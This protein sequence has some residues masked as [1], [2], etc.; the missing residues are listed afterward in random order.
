V[1]EFSLVERN[2]SLMLVPES[3][4]IR[5]IS[6]SSGMLISAALMLVA[7]F[8]FGSW[9]VYSSYKVEQLA[10][11]LEQSQHALDHAQ[12]RYDVKMAEWQDETVSD[13]KKLAVYSR[14]LGQMQARLSRLD[15]LGSKLV[16][17][18]ALDK[19]EFDFGVQPAFGGP[20]QTRPDF[21]GLEAG[22][23][24]GLKYLDGRMEQL[25]TQLAAIDYMLENNRS[26]AHAKPHAWPTEGGWL[27][28]NYGRRMDPFT[29]NPAN[30][31]GVDIANRFGAP[32]LASSR[33]IVTFAGKMKDFGYMV[34][35]DHGYGYKTRYGHMSSVSVKVGDVVNDSQILGR[36]GSSGRSTGPH[37]HYEVHLHGMHINPA[38]YLPRS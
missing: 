4:R 13:Q 11:T 26:V 8:S 18:A 22:L 34:D 2:Y 7:L 1:E 16:N 19:S 6:L 9:G 20:R 31:Y 35:V 30:H 14:T 32:V 36:I 17:V 21:S 10:L 25:D 23:H 15:S 28:S 29:G 37:L 38:S 24:D 5:R 33:G 3:G 12:S 27:S